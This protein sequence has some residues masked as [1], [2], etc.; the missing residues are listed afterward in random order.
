[1]NSANHHMAREIGDIGWFSL[2]QALQKIRPESVEKREL[3]LRVGCILRN[4][5]AI[6][7]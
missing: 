2:E 6:E 4:F 1:M 3:L 7:I 5:S